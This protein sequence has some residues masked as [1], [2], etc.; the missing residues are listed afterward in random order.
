MDEEKIIMLKDFF[1]REKIKQAEIAERTGI[2]QPQV[3]RLLAGRDNFGKKTAAAWSQA[4]G[5]N[6]MWLMTGDGDMMLDKS[7]QPAAAD[8]LWLPVL[9][10]DTRGGTAPNDETDT[11][12]YTTKLMPFSRS[13]AREGD[14]VMQVVGES[15]RPL[16]PSGCY[17]LVRPLPT[18]REYLELGAVYVLDLL[19]GRRII[20]EVRAGSDAQ[21][22]A[23]CSVNPRF[24]PSDIAKAFI[25]HVYAV[26][27]SV[28]RDYNW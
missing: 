2:S 12:Q 25:A 16:Y 13:T 23:L 21:H 22:F 27:I 26:I 15:M 11:L 3:N 19:D 18:W 7:Q 9:N 5:F 6:P 24:D 28:R 20:K 17:V 14:F 8:V 4:F 10:F 1:K